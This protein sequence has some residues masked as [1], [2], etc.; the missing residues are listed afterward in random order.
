MLAGFSR[1]YGGRVYVMFRDK[2]KEHIDLFTDEGSK[3]SFKHKHELF[4]YLNRKNNN[5]VSRTSY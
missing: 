2:S 5:G 4:N 3:L 1:Y